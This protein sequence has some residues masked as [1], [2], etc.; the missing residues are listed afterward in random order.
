MRG[1]YLTNRQSSQGLFY[2]RKLSLTL[3]CNKTISCVETKEWGR[4]NLA[5]TA[6]NERVGRVVV[7][8]TVILSSASVIAQAF[9]F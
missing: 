4:A 8:N 7:S 2:R 1:V 3:I 5:P 9:D 6:V